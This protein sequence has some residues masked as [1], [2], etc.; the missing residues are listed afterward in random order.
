MICDHISEDLGNLI[1]NPFS[2]DSAASHRLLSLVVR[3]IRFTA[4]EREAD[5]DLSIE[6]Q[7][8]CDLRCH[9]AMIASGRP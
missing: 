6:N 5:E 2:L 4:V 3:E 7:L 9:S 8:D 1:D